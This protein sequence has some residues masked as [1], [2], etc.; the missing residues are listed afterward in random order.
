MLSELCV[1]RPV[2]ATML[3]MS[4]VVL[5]LFSFRG[6]SVDLY[7]RA[8]PATV[9]VACTLKGAS[10]EEMATSVVMPLEEALSSISGIDELNSTRIGEGGATIT[11]KFTLDRDL[12]DAASDVRE[13]VA[14]AQKNLP[15]EME[16]PIIT[17]VD[18]DADP[19]LTLVISSRDLTLR[20]LT[21]M[22]DKQIKRAI[23]TVDGVGEVSMAGGRAREIH[24]VMDVDKLNAHGLSVNQVRDAV[25][26]ENVEV[27]GGTLDQ[28][29]SELVL[30]TLGRIDATDQFNHI[31]IATVNGTPVKVSDIGYVEDGVEEVRSG[32]W[33]DGKPAIV[34]DI[35]RQTGQNTVKVIE[36][37]RKKMKQVVPLLPKSVNIATQRD[38]SQFIYQSISALEEH[39]LF[40]SLLA[41]LVVLLFIRNFRAVI[42]A[43]LAIP[44]SIIATFTLMRVGDFTL[45]AM[46]LLGLTL[47]VGI[48][49]DDAIV[50]LENIFRHIEEKKMAP[51]QAAIAG[52]REVT[53][54]VMATTL[55]LIVIFLPVAFMTGYS[56]R[57][58]YPFGMTM[59]FAI[60]VSMIV[61]FTLTPMLSSR[62]LKISDAEADSKTK[63]TGFFRRIDEVYTAS[64]RWA[65]G[66]PWL[67]LGSAVVI[68]LFTFPLNAMLGRTFIPNEDVGDYQFTLDGPEGISL[69]GMA[70]KVN[71][72]AARVAKIEGVWHTVPTISERVNH[73]HIMILLKPRDERRVTLDEVVGRTHDI[74]K[75]Y[76]AWRPAVLLRGAL[77]GGEAAS[78]PIQGSLLG[79]DLP[80][81]AEYA[82][83]TVAMMQKSPV[84]TDQKVGVNLANP[85]I[86]VAVN[87]QRA[88][89]LGVRIST[90]A[91]TLR[92][93]VAGE[94]EISYYREGQEQYPVKMR[95]LDTQRRD[96]ASVA[97]LTV[98]SARGP[99]RI[100]NIATL[101]RG[102][103]PTS[104]ERFNRQ[105]SV[106]IRA[107]IAPGYALDQAAAEVRQIVKNVDLAPGFSLKMS[108]QTQILEETTGNMMLA[109][110]LAFIFVYMV[111]AAQ[112]ESFIQP[113]VIMLA[114]P[115]SMPFALFTIW[116]TGRTLNLW[117]ALGI[118]LLLGIVKKNSILQ[119]D[120]AN[121]LRRQGVPLNEAI[122]E[123]CRTRLRPILMTTS[124]I[125]AGLVPTALGIGAGGEQRATIAVTIIGGQAL[126]LFLTLLLVPVAYVKFDVLEPAAARQWLGAAVARV[127]GRARG[128]QTAAEDAS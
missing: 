97:R 65:L 41:S 116:V 111:L 24:I 107:G 35:R 13:K 12:D 119:V 124:A 56:R 120:Y 110:G 32:A 105:F 80:R 59:A 57:F 88:A 11:V 43:S 9:S 75:D 117:S 42:I 93:M 34:L 67:V 1:R 69:E 94:D 29:K 82:M 5:G 91:Q 83:R 4:L 98:P 58:I 55:S 103:G 28:G 87:R 92:L 15:P 21:E 112:F 62:F 23:E 6:L 45:N 38:D 7:P 36:A 108:G 106:S 66:R 31:V 60:L 2:F 81:L 126:C 114:L 78:F 33:M 44:A 128:P 16:P 125:L 70:E 122:V 25:Q 85:E 53:L 46:T 95:V 39:L 72:V 73:S 18:P 104:L 71:E 37:V 19:V 40:G 10:P 109:I 3:V 90:V 89:D 100:D 48:V 74:L 64:L 68:F 27:P 79:A 50:V 61:S 22:T 17:K 101:E 63:E 54:P 102:M 121:V 76:P 47:A 86:R 123:A 49:I 115:L 8:D 52:T 84:L 113:I 118:L 96:I 20:A 127:T 26:S 77:G 14:R 30:R 51:F 99:V